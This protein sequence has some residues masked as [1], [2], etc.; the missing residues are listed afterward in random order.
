MNL[1][2]LLVHDSDLPA[3]QWTTTDT[4]WCWRAEQPIRSYYDWR[5]TWVV[6][7]P[8]GLQMRSHP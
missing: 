1:L 4:A 8:A 3:E 2:D 6:C 5:Q 7:E